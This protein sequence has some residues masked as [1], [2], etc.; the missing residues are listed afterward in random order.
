[1]EA[2]V[3]ELQERDLTFHPTRNSSPSALSLEQIAKFN[4]D[5]FVGPLDVYHAHE[6]A[7]TRGYFD[8]LL[9][10]VLADGQ[11][12]YSI[13]V[14]QLKLGRV[15]DMLKDPRIVR[16]VADLLGENLI[17]WGAHFFCKLP[18]DGKCVAWHQDIS[19]WPLSKSKSVTVWLAVDPAGVDNGCMRFIAGSHHFGP[20]T[21]RRC[22]PEEHSVLNLAVENPEQYGRLYDNVLGAGQCSVHS[23]LLLHGSAANNSQRRR[24]GLALRYCAADVRGPSEWAARGVIV[25]GVDA[26]GYWGNPPRPSQD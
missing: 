17:G 23:D 18:G 15:Y 16:Y 4:Q 11:D 1:V 25:S 3:L 22:T 14:A 6:I 12:S 8:A 13:S 20:L 7:E 10:R 24:C 2:N 9:A 21:F 5:G 19:Y 26:S